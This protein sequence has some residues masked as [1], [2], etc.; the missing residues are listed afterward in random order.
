MCYI[1]SSEEKS[2]KTIATTT[3]KDEALFRVAVLLSS[4]SYNCVNCNDKCSF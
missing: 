1:I 3:K 2:E 4:T